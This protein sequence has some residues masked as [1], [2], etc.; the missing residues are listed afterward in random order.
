MSGPLPIRTV[1]PACNGGS[2]HEESLVVWEGED[3]NVLA[4]CHRSRCEIGTVLVSGTMNIPRVGMEIAHWQPAPEH[5]RATKYSQGQ[6]LTKDGALWIHNKCRFPFPPRYVDVYF[7]SYNAGVGKAERE[8]VYFPMLDPNQEQRGCILK[9]IHPDSELPKS[10]TYKD[11]GYD[12]MSWYLTTD[13]MIQRS[14]VLVEDVLSALA[15]LACGMS[16]ISL[17]GTM[18]NPDRLVTISKYKR[19]IHVALDADAT[20]KAVRYALRYGTRFNLKVMRLM[21]DFKDMTK[22]ELKEVLSGI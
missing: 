4:T 18:L 20:A 3:G 2:D 16:S 8:C 21:K 1:C 22:D 13:H 17:N 6:P 9:P 7:K 12:G 10:L 15:V 14:I 11:E 5:L 19:V